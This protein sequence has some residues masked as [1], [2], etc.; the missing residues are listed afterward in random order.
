MLLAAFIASL[1]MFEREMPCCRAM[2]QPILLQKM[3]QHLVHGKAT[4]KT[5][6]NKR[7]SFTD[8]NVNKTKLITSICINEND[9]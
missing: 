3:I 4:L 9:S 5:I 7:I 6:G 1:D 2:V 8:K